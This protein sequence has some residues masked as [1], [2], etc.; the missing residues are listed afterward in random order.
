MP[1]AP[2]APGT[3]TRTKLKAFQFIEGKP[4]INSVDNEADKENARRQHLEVPQ[5]TPVKPQNQTNAEALSSRI[6]PSTPATRLPLADLIGNPD[7][8]LV[9]T[10][11]DT[12]EEH[13]LWLHAQTPTSP[14]PAVTP[15]RKRKR[16]RSSSP[17]SSQNE[18][19][20]FSSAGKEPFDVQGLQQSLKT[21]QAD[22]AADLWSR[23]ASAND[24][25]T[26]NNK[27]TT[28]A[29]LICDS[30]PRSS[31]TKGSISGLRRWASCGV[32][33][34]VSATKSKKR[35]IIRREQEQSDEVTRHL[36]DGEPKK[37]KVGLLLERMKES[38]SKPPEN[39]PE[40][41][42]S[43]S[44]L[45]ERPVMGDYESPLHRLAPVQE[46]ESPLNQQFS[47]A[48]GNH[49]LRKSQSTSSEYG[50]DDI[51]LD[52]LEIFESTAVAAHSQGKESTQ[53]LSTI[54]E[55]A[56]PPPIR[57]MRDCSAV[58]QRSQPQPPVHVSAAP[59]QIVHDEFDGEDDDIFA[60]DLEQIAS[61]YDSRAAQPQAQ[62]PVQR[63]AVSGEKR[64]TVRGP[65]AQSVQ[66]LSDDEFGDDDIDDEQFAAAEIAAT[67]A[68]RASSVAPVSVCARSCS[69]R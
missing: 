67:Q 7:E 19:S 6:L 40:A 41:P 48:R 57:E 3:Q 12:P 21:P 33:W 10:N 55:E 62:Q 59:P 9:S 27:P 69:G 13:V 31:A 22:P 32:E 39:I 49:G 36:D 56:S 23:Y 46:E 66:V 1:T 18:A 14:R 37:S 29:H 47:S 2:I 24:G 8:K 26:S 45:P 4:C 43:S 64:G 17:P 28:F 52:M 58:Q 44:P 15:A 42:S 38:L 61:V 54:V 5:Q 34:P 51:D 25:T 30:S 60:E 68:F 65:P 50:G 53:N 35:R 11:T 16:A 20:N 63:A